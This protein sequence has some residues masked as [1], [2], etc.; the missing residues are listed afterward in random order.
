MI[1]NSPAFRRWDRGPPILSPGG[2]AEAMF[3]PPVREHGTNSLAQIAS[4]SPRR[5]GFAQ[6]GCESVD[7]RLPAQNVD[8]NNINFRE[9]NAVAGRILGPGDVV[10]G[11]SVF[12]PEIN[13]IRI[14]VLSG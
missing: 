9:E 5:M 7:F 3:H 12:L 2:T 11:N 1:E 13:V 4:L 8:A 10:A 6:H 14:D